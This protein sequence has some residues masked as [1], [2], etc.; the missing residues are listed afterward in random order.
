[1]DS[2]RLHIKSPPAQKF[3]SDPMNTP[4]FALRAID[5]VVLRVVDLDNM[6]SF[7]RDV[8]GC[9]DERAQPEL[10][11]SHL[12]AGGSLTAL[13]PIDGQLGASGGQ[14]PG[15]AGRKRHHLARQARDGEKVVR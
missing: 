5:H 14:A 2:G 15:R 6:A 9:T 1:M 3:R 11:L 8:L 12:R 13:V 7:Y 4:P 10:G